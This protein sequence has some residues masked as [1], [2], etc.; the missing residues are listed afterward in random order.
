MFVNVSRRTSHA[1]CCPEVPPPRAER[2]REG[3]IRGRVRPHGRRHRRR[4]RRHGLRPRRLRQQRVRQHLQRAPCPHV[5]V[6]PGSVILSF[7]P[8][9]PRRPPRPFVVPSVM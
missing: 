4:H 1:C 7:S 2:R 6:L 5:G 8:E 3:R 9:G